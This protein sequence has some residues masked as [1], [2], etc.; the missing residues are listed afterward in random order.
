MNLKEACLEKGGIWNH[1][2]GCKVKETI[3][4]SGESVERLY[5]PTTERKCFENG[6]EHVHFFDT[7]HACKELSVKEFCGNKLDGDFGLFTCARAVE[8]PEK[9]IFQVMESEKR[10]LPDIYKHQKLTKRLRIEA[11]NNPELDEYKPSFYKHVKLDKNE[12]EVAL[13]KEIDAVSLSKNTESLVNMIGINTLTTNQIWDMIFLSEKVSDIGNEHIK[14]LYE[15]QRLSHSQIIHAID[16]EIQLNSLYKVNYLTK[17]QID[18]AI[19]KGKSLNHIYAYQSLSK[20]QIDDILFFSPQKI[21]SHFYRSQ[22]LT[23]NQIDK[24]INH[25]KFISLLIQY[26]KLNLRQISTIIKNNIQDVQVINKLIERY[27][28][29]LNTTQRIYLINHGNPY[30]ID[31]L[32]HSIQL[33]TN[34]LYEL[35]SKGKELEHVVLYQKLSDDLIKLYIDKGK[36]LHL[37]YNWAE[38]SPQS[39]QYAIDNG[40]YLDR[41]I[42]RYGRTLSNRQIDQMI[43]QGTSLATL[44]GHWYKI[45]EPHQVDAAVKKGKSLAVLANKYKL[46]DEHIDYIIQNATESELVHFFSLGKR[47]HSRIELNKE[48][49]DKAIERGIGTDALFSF[50]E[51]T[52]HQKYKAIAV[53]ANLQQLYQSHT[54]TEKMI[55]AA[56][57]KGIDL[58]YLYSAREHGYWLRDA[59]YKHVLTKTQVDKAIEKGEALEELYKS[60]NFTSSQITKAIEN[61][62]NLSA[63]IGR[64]KLSN[65]QKDEILSMGRTYVKPFY[66]E[67]EVTDA[68]YDIALSLRELYKKQE[69]NREQIKTAID[70]GFDLSE[71][72]RNT[73][74]LSDELYIQALER[75]KDLH[76]LMSY[77]A[78]YFSI[79]IIEHALNMKEDIANHI[80]TLYR[81]IKIKSDEIN[82]LLELN[83]GAPLLYQYHAKNFTKSNFKKAIEVGV[84]SG[85]LY[86]HEMTGENI[87]S[88]IKH[89]EYL[90]ILYTY[91]KL[92]PKQVDLALDMEKNLHELYEHQNLTAKQ[93][94]R[95]IEIGEDI[96][97]LW[98][99]HKDEFTKK[100]ID[101]LIEKRK[102]LNTLQKSPLVSDEQKERILEIRGISPEVLSKSPFLRAVHSTLIPEAKEIYDY[103]VTNRIKEHPL[104]P[105]VGVYEVPKTPWVEIIDALEKE[106]WVVKNEQFAYKG[107]S[108]KKIGRLLSF[109][110]DERLKKKYQ[111]LRS[112]NTPLPE[113]IEEIMIEISDDPDDM[114]MKSTGQYWESCETAT[115]SA[116]GGEDLKGPHIGWRDD[117]I[118]NNVIAYLK[119][120]GEDKPRA[121]TII[122]WCNREDDGLPDAFVEAATS[123][124][125]DVK[126][127]DIIKDNV[128][129]ILRR[130]GY[131]GISG[132]VKCVTPYKYTGYVDYFRAHWPNEPIIYSLAER[133]EVE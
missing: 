39:I 12:L 78:K 101:R 24:A 22:K 10:I 49:I 52:P 3:S 13:R 75:K 68:T 64:Y 88:A 65:K 37:L 11:M 72:Y 57:E 110:D 79:N 8:F 63:L 23:R 45:L 54:L 106:G 87:Y 85:D 35:I 59:K 9:K 32:F 83:I 62:Q 120:K 2:I 28:E 29:S 111:I 33:R 66:G 86:R 97:N 92:T 112:Q 51:L 116:G 60:Q 55:D 44:Y 81:N 53:G 127:R 40:L 109:V 131:T 73:A 41:I 38:L 99:Y 70:I 67:P 96:D 74:K 34:E 30:V 126:Y 133:P 104:K 132:P 50:Y 94:R 25:Q 48:Q 100:D 89:G 124:K 18:Y 128:I 5:Y 95:A 77:H 121:R 93:R 27:G 129:D 113:K 1:R 56:I 102:I 19:E 90:N 125:R 21:Q 4:H 114:A 17:D 122:R 69:L 107:K 115:H 14:M 84:A 80:G 61:K 91:N 117:I 130:K 20:E 119:I 15:K 43:E 71:V 103:A 42:K 58:E 16:N 47:R 76:A 6:D 105:L 98:T 108:K 118:A 123:H 7:V 46:T 31:T 82:K 36:D 26:Q